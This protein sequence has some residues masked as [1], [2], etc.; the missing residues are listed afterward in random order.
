MGNGNSRKEEVKE[1]K[2]K[3]EEIINKM[4]YS[5]KNLKININEEFRKLTNNYKMQSNDL[6]KFLSYILNMVEE[7]FKNLKNY[8]KT[9]VDLYNKNESFNKNNKEPKNSVR[10]QNLQIHRTLKS[11]KE[12][13][14]SFNNIP[15]LLN[16]DYFT[17]KDIQDENKLFTRNF[18][19]IALKQINDDDENDETITNFL[20]EIH[21][22]SKQSFSHSKLLLNNMINY[23]RVE[24]KKIVKL[25]LD[26]NEEIKKEFSSW[27]KEF[28]KKNKGTQIYKNFLENKRLNYN[29][30]EKQELYNNIFYQL[31]ILYFHCE[32]S[33]PPVSINFRLDQN[34]FDSETMIDIIN[35]GRGKIN[36]VFLPS[37]FSNGNFIENGKYW[38]YT[39]K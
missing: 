12:S 20:K 22:I 13:N 18:Q 10:K 28:E 31:T 8:I 16:L 4:N 24:K 5:E 19:K 32:L 14:E 34:D 3:V 17:S 1:V 33:F 2:D 29:N 7:E 15:N 38:V 27:I 39:S 6:S 11:Y 30:K 9:G 23:F 21:L 37:L 25:P 36:F 26:T 35:M